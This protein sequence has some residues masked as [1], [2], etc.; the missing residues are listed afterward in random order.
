MSVDRIIRALNLQSFDITN[1]QNL[2]MNHR[3]PIL[4]FP[5]CAFRT[6]TRHKRKTAAAQ[7]LV[8]LLVNRIDILHL[9]CDQTQLIVQRHKQI[10][11][12]KM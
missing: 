1:F 11:F 6:N 4:V 3:A 2:S 7:I 12:A 10:E 5:M 9:T 8:L